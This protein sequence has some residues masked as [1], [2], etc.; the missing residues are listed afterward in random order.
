MVGSFISHAPRGLLVVLPAGA[1]A[2]AVSAKDLSTAFA[3]RCYD[4][5][6]PRPGFHAIRRGSGDMM[7]T[8]A[9]GQLDLTS[10]PVR[11]AAQLSGGIDGPEPCRR[12]HDDKAPLRQV[13]VEPRRRRGFDWR[14]VTRQREGRNGTPGISKTQLR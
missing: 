10:A 6:L 4:V 8:G 14:V 2:P 9:A 3:T 13:N 1:I 11:T 12:G 5:G 7:R